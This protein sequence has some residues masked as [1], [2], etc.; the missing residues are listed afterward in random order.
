DIYISKLDKIR[1]NCTIIKKN[2]PDTFEKFDNLGLVKDGIYKRYEHSVELI[3]DL[4][5]MLNADLKLGIPNGTSDIFEQLSKNKILTLE[6]I[7]IIKG[8]KGFRNILIH[9]YGH[10]DD[11]QAFHIIKE[12]LSDFEIIEKE[13]VKIIKNQQ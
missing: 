5:A 13:I 6:I 9:R 7:E 10:L 2:L 4:I 1:E 12:K 3:I 11:K 8:M